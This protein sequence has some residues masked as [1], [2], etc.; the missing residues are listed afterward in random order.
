[1]IVRHSRI[2]DGSIE[3]IFDADA[4]T[5]MNTE[6]INPLV[7]EVDYA[8]PVLMKGMTVVLGSEEEHV[9]IE[10]TTPD[11][12]FIFKEEFQASN[13]NKT[14]N[15]NFEK[16]YEVKSF[17]YIQQDPNAIPEAIMHLWEITPIQ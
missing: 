17:R 8:E 7:I 4:G 6:K 16:T 11:G 2:L 1:M 14:V 5:Y 12:N 13:G 3:R 15:F 10:L 9:T